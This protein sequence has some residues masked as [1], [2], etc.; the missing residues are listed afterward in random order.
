MQHEGYFGT[1]LVIF[2]LGQMMRTLPELAQPLSKFHAAPMGGRLATA[3]DLERNRPH[4]RRIFSAVG[5][6]A[7]SPPAPN[8]KPCH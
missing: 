6:R 1:D 8:P 3:C 5:F 4:T 2:N 7:W